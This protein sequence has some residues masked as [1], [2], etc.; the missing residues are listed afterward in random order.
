MVE[1]IDSMKERILSAV[2]ERVARNGF[3][4]LSVDEL[5]A[6]M[7]MSKKTF[8]KVFE[9]K[10]QMIG[11]FVDRTM[12][13]IGGA[14][15]RIIATDV[16]F[17]DKLNAVMADLGTIS[18]R[19]DSLL[20]SDIHRMMP[21]LWERIEE[22]RRRKIHDNFSRLIAQGVQEGYVRK[23]LH[24]RLLILAYIACIQAVVRPSVLSEESFSA[25]EAIQQ[26]V[27]MLFVGIMTDE[28]RKIFEQHQEPIQ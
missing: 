9:S 25:K 16:G 21:H 4:R 3:A 28:G 24:Q 23:D 26:I 6:S 13:E 19:I 11:Q 17:V 27:R 7:G 5:T 20:A 8:Y 2:K 22:F 18:Q 10:E 12:G 15:D 14:L 1:P